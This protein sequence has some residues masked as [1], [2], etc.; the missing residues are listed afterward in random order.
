MNVPTGIARPDAEALEGPGE[1]VGVVGH[2]AVAGTAHAVAG[3]GHA[4]GVGVDAAAM[5]EDGVDG[6]GRLAHGRADHA[7]VLSRSSVEPR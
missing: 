7:G 5:P 4:L 2:L 3:E 6:E 1:T